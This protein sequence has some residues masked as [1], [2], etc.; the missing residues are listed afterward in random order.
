[1]YCTFV[2]HA[3]THASSFTRDARFALILFNHRRIRTSSPEARRVG[4]MTTNA[5]TRAS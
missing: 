1:M 2:L 3:S 5:P 4:G